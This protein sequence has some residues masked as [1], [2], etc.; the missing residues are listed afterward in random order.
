M[1]A[2]ESLLVEDRPTVSAAYESSPPRFV[3][4]DVSWSGYEQIGDALRDRP[5]LRLTYDRGSLELMTTSQR[6]E[7]GKKLLGRLVETLA[8]ECDLAVL[9][10]G[11][12]TFRRED[13][14]RGLEPDE[15]YWIAHQQEMQAREDW[16]PSADPPPDLVIEIEITRSAL[17]RMGIYAALGVPEVW[18]YDG[19][20][21]E[22]CL[23]TSDGT[24]RTSSTSPTFPGFLAEEVPRVSRSRT[25]A[26]LSPDRAPIPDAGARVAKQLN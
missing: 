20:R 25:R 19:G 21:L 5:A 7:R 14:R 1:T 8:E 17:P 10:A 24:Y 15:S 18:R 9:P 11:S 13:L 6:H 3:L 12:M 23:L 16:D 2:V 26:G 4:H 22:I